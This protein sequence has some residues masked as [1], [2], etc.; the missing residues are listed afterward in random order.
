MLD[1]ELED[2]ECIVTRKTNRGDM[3]VKLCTMTGDCQCGNYPCCPVD[4]EV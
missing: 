4:E 3:A 2:N 1:S